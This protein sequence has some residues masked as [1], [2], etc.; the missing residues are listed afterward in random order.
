MF[1]VLYSWNFTFLP[2]WYSWL[3]SFNCSG[4]LWPCVVIFYDGLSLPISD[5]C[6]KISGFMYYTY[7]NTDLI[8]CLRLPI[9]KMSYSPDKW[10]FLQFTH[11][12]LTLH[13]IKVLYL[14]ISRYSWLTIHTMTEYTTWTFVCISVSIIF[15][16]TFWTSV[17]LYLTPNVY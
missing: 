10:S 7:M 2:L 11:F 3:N 1:Y 9:C 4:C 13:F 12:R 17:N 8:V 15:I 6:T 5:G 14:L 16:I